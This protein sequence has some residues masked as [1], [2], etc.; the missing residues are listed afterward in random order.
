MK[1]PELIRAAIEAREQWSP[2]G[3]QIE[4]GASQ[5]FS[6]RAETQ[7]RLAGVPKSNPRVGLRAIVGTA[8]HSYLEKIVPRFDDSVLSEQKYLY[9][10]TPATVDL[11]VS[12][13]LWDYKTTTKDKLAAI[14]RDGP[15]ARQRGQIH[16]G[17]AAAR[18]A[19]V[20]V[21][22]VGLLFIPVDSNDLDDIWA[23]SE[24]FSQ[25]LADQAADFHQEQRELAEANR[26]AGGVPDLNGLRD[27][28][29]HFCEAFCAWVDICR[30]PSRTP[31]ATDPALIDLAQRYMT[32]KIEADEAYARVR[33]YKE[34]LQQAPAMVVDGYKLAW[35]GGN[36]KSETVVDIEELKR[37]FEMLVGPL[38]TTELETFTA[39]QFRMTKA[40][41]AS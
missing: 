39:R 19:G 28:P 32:A 11:I 34:Q 15:T 4:S 5:T 10:G 23:W 13:E 6:C 27:E 25:D 21:E 22:H 41:R 37:S 7:L 3:Q 16:L 14:R 30:G 35:S 9:R 20:V 26:E 24:P 40:R 8:V 17:A 36:A 29:T 2:R 33:Y 1:G 31:V 38:P 12:P 18:E